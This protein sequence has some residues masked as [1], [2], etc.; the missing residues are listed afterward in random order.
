MSK[1]SEAFEETIQRLLPLIGTGALEHTEVLTHALARLVWAADAYGVAPAPQSPARAL[2]PR[3]GP[4]SGPA[5]ASHGD[6]GVS[7]RSEEARLGGE[8]EEAA[9]ENE[10]H[11]GQLPKGLHDPDGVDRLGGLSKVQSRV[12]RPNPPTGPGTM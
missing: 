3:G 8:R 4:R 9:G 1:T 10:V 6:S 11:A 5:H 12:F 7:H 2:P